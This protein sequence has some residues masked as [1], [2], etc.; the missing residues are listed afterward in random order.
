MHYSCAFSDEEAGPACPETE[1]ALDDQLLSE[2]EGASD[3]QLLGEAD[4]ASNSWP[5]SEVTMHFFVGDEHA[6]AGESHCAVRDADCAFCLQS[7]CCSA[8]ELSDGSASLCG[9]A[10]GAELMS[11]ADGQQVHVTV[12]EAA[13]E[14]AMPEVVPTKGVSPPKEN[15]FYFYQGKQFASI[16]QFFGGVLSVNRLLSPAKRRDI[17]L[18]LSVCPSVRHALFGILCAYRL[19]DYATHNHETCTI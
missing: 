14:L 10:A 7:S 15:A 13:E 8:S 6:F 17:V 9:T 16:N 12:D 5:L 11:H 2:A 18:D 3:T 19:R 4:Q 1:P